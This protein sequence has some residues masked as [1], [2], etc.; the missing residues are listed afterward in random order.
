VQLRAPKAFHERTLR[1]EFVA[2]CDELDAHLDELTTRVI[3]EAI[4]EDVSEA[5]EQKTPKALPEANSLNPRGRD[6]H[7]DPRGQ[8]EHYRRRRARASTMRASC[9][10]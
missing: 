10:G 5:P 3:R 6:E 7:A 4:N 2:L 9:R 8:R 1:P